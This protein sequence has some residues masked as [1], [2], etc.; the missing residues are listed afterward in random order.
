MLRIN[1]FILPFIILSTVS[2]SCSKNNDSKKIVESK[3]FKTIISNEFENKLIDLFINK[4]YQNGTYSYNNDLTYDYC[5]DKNVDY[6]DFF[7][8]HKLTKNEIYID[9]TRGFFGNS[10][11]FSFTF[12]NRKI[13]DANLILKSKAYLYYKEP[14]NKVYYDQ[15]I[16]FDK[17]CFCCASYMP[18]VYNGEEI[19]DLFK[20]YNEG[21]FTYN[22]KQNLIYPLSTK[23]YYL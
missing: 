7:D 2:F 6:L 15:F 20:A 5:K 22:E 10:L 9:K 21:V 4:Y 14:L 12:N 11:V 23:Y 8:N 16:E 1:K 13:T 18:F 17:P 19:I 3:S